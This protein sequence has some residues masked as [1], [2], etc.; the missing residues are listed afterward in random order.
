MHL[1]LKFIGEVEG[2]LINDIINVLDG[3]HVEPF[4]VPVEGLGAFPHRGPPQVTWVGVGRGH[5]RLFQ[6]QYRI[7]NALLALGIEPDMRGYHPHITLAHTSKAAPGAVHHFLKRHRSF[8]A[9]PFRATA[10]TLFSS[11]ASSAGQIYREEATW[12]MVEHPREYRRYA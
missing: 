8:E 11:H 12:P 1:T 5:P 4:H 6:L 10:F 9:P 7:E 3:I 2:G